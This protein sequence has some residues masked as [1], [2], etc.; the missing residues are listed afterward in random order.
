MFSALGR[1]ADPN[2]EIEQTFLNGFRTLFSLIRKY[3]IENINGD[4]V[5][6]SSDDEMRQAVVN[7]L[8][9]NGENQTAN[10]DD[11]FMRTFINV[12]KAIASAHRRNFNN[13][14]AQ[15]V[16]DLADTVF[17]FI[18]K[19]NGENQ[20]TGEEYFKKIISL[21]NN[22]IIPAWVKGAD[23]GRIRSPDGTGKAKTPQRSTILGSLATSVLNKY[24]SG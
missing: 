14:F 5:I 8:G 12:L 18:G 10:D 6:Q 4:G 13:E 22:N 17:S 9:N 20:P 1:N 15:A 21:V 24:L 2:D 11:E 3:K 23:K 7:I 16:F 19:G